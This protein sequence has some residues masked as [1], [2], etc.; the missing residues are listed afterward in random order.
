MSINL[1]S[2]FRGFMPVVIDVESGGI[3]PSTDALL[4]L[5]AITLKMD[6]DGLLM[7]DNTYHY[8]INPFENAH[9]DP[10]AL[11]FNKIDPHQ[12][13][14]FAVDE[15]EALQDLFKHIK[16]E[17]KTKK[18]QRAVVVGHNAWF[19]LH[20]LNA[21][22][23]RTQ[24]VSPFH[25]FTSFDTATLCALIYGQTVLSKALAMAKIEFKSDDAHSALYDAQ[26]TASLFCK[27]IND[28]RNRLMRL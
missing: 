12:P 8:H 17:C 3:N 2:R 10:K 16:E 5:A 7:P 9:L 26:A 28:Y 24:L 14:R 11:A 21:A 6:D 20:F 22:V 25:R 1:A 18:C 4:E 23:T 15:K 13:L 19:D 27:I